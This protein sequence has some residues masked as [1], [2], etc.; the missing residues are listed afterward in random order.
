MELRHLAAAFR[1][2]LVPKEERMKKSFAL[3]AALLGSLGVVASA[4]ATV[5]PIAPNGDPYYGDCPG[6]I[7]GVALQGDEQADVMVGTERADRLR[8]RGGNDTIS[9]LGSGDCLEGGKGHDDIFGG[10]GNDFIQGA[11]G[12]DDILG[13]G[14]N[15]RIQGNRGNDAIDGGDGNDVLSGGPG[16]DDISGGAGDDT[17]HAAD[18]D[19]DRV[20]CGPGSDTA[21]VDK[22]DQVTNCETVNR[23]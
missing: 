15:D 4:T 22:R 16:Q 11:E 14:G 23:Q 10:E 12:N 20:D 8:G 5:T 19:R 1:R 13:Q 9:G 3:A 6:R 17:I 2:R 7:T 21:F 18:G